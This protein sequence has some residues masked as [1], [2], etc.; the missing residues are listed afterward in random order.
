M[1]P[2]LYLNTYFAIEAPRSTFWS[3]TEETLTLCGDESTH[4]LPTKA[5]FCPEC[6]AQV[7]SK[8]VEEPAPALRAFADELGVPPELAFSELID[9]DGGWEWTAD[10][11]LQVPLTIRW[12]SIDG[13]HRV[14]P[15]VKGLGFQLGRVLYL[16]HSNKQ[17]TYSI[18][19]LA[20]YHIALLEVAQKFN[21]SGEPRLWL[22]VEVSESD[23]W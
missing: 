15:R 21:I 7:V 9:P 23:H 12:H 20:P 14:L 16:D 6:G 10:N 18:T 19:E 11:G 2:T 8:P 3:P 5:K 13:F 1:I 17:L 4:V 22:Q